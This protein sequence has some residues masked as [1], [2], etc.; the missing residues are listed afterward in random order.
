M[1][2]KCCLV[3]ESVQT[4]LR[5]HEAGRPAADP[6]AAWRE[7]LSGGDAA[8]GRILFRDR[9]DVACLRCHAIKGEGGPAGPALD[10]LAAKRDRVYLLAALLAPNQAIAPGFEN[11]VV[12]MQDGKVYA[13]TVKGEDAA[14]LRLESPE[15]GLV[16][17]DKSRISS[18]RAGLSAM[19]EGMEKMLSKRELRDL[20]EFL[21]SLR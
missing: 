4:L 5:R 3:D 15:D 9:A 2:V 20:V 13:G 8:A 14:E 7:C 10:G 19:P 17:L 18:R 11:A 1:I 16:K 21:A 6:L 12:T